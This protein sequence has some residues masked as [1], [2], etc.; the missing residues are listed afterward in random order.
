VGIHKQRYTIG[1]KRVNGGKLAAHATRTHMRPTARSTIDLSTTTETT[2]K[3]D[4]GPQ[5]S[6]RYYGELM[7]KPR[8]KIINHRG[9]DAINTRNASALSAIAVVERRLVEMKRQLR[10]EMSN[11]AIDDIIDAANRAAQILDITL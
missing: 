1:D 2:V 8:I 7:S 4:W 11:N 5:Q 6:K 10:H 9:A 3:P